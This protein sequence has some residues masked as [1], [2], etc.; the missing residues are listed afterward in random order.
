MPDKKQKLTKANLLKE[1][2]NKLQSLNLLRSALSA[3][4]SRKQE[5]LE[6][7]QRQ[8]RDLITRIK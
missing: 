1:M 4:A 3:D 2:D 7:Y 8:F 6:N 5:D